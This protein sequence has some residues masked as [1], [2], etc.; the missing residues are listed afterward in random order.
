MDAK[1]VDNRPTMDLVD[2]ESGERRVQT[3]EQP[4]QRE[5][6]H[7]GRDH[8]PRPQADEVSGEQ[9][10]GAGSRE[11]RALRRIRVFV[12]PAGVE[13]RPGSA[14]VSAALVTPVGALVC[15]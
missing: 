15:R 13:M 3:R 9:G 7:D 8:K 12:R 2:D 1:G 10:H 5:V 11:W 6:Q 4:G 14:A